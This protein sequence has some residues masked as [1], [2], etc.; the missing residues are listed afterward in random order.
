MYQLRQTPSL[1]VC[2]EAVIVLH[3]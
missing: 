3:Y 1:L 2:Q